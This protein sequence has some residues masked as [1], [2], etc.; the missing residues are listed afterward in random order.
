M[1]DISTGSSLLDSVKKSLADSKGQWPEI[2]T[3]TGVPYFTISKIAS[4]ATKNPGVLHVETLANYFKA[5]QE[6]AA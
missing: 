3:A 5:Q 6:K 1:S 2:A 4:G